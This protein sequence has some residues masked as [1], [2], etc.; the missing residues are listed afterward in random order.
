MLRSLALGLIALVAGCRS[1]QPA[2]DLER[3]AIAVVS[4]AHLRTD[5]VGEGE[6]ATRATFV[7]VDAENR[8]TSDANVT[9][10]GEL[11]DAGGQVLATLEP[12]SLW[13]GAGDRRTFALVDH[14][15]RE[16]T[17][18]ASGRVFVRG[19]KV[20]AT[21]PVMEVR[22]VHTFDDGGRVVVQGTLHNG[23][24]RPGTAMVI[25][26]FY[27]RD[28]RPLTR[29]FSMIPIGGNFDRHL[30][31]VGPPGSTRAALYVGPIVY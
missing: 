13:L 27:D 23:I 10:G 28:D 15:R 9:L 8:S 26:S 19:A 25:A 17:G 18:A 5:V 7:L 4:A 14:E 29:P 20:A 31:F 1:H 3:G 12:E 30:Q 22:D 11:L 6:F 2:A 16:R 21:P 24:A